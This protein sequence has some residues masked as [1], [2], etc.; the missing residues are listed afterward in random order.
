MLLLSFSLSPHLKLELVSNCLSSGLRTLSF[1][2]CCQWGHEYQL[3]VNWAKTK[4]FIAIV[5][6]ALWLRPG[7]VMTFDHQILLIMFFPS[8]LV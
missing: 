3:M 7:P 2:H 1:D 6:P 4:R 5:E 8:D